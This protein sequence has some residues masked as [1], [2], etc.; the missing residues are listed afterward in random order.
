[1]L[2]GNPLRAA[3]ISRKRQAVLKAGF[4]M[5]VPRA[6]VFFVPG[7]DA[8]TG[9][10][11][12]ILSIADESRRLQSI[13]GASV[14]V[15]TLPGHPPL[16][17]YTRFDNSET[18]LGIE[19]VWGVLGASPA[20][21]IHVPEVHV[22]EALRWLERNRARIP[23]DTAINVLLQNVDL[24]PS[25]ADM[26]RLASFGSLSCTTAHKAYSTPEFEARLGCP[27]HHLSAWVSPEGYKRLDV[28]QKD[29]LVI[30][31]RDVTP[32]KSDVLA[33]LQ[34]AM[35]L[36]AF[37]EIAGLTYQ[38]YKELITRARF[39]VTFGEGLD[40]YLVEPV[41]SGGVGSAVYNDRFFTPDFKALDFI[42]SSWDDLVGRFPEDAA[43]CE[44][45]A[46]YRAVNARQ[47]EHL[48]G[49]YSKD[50]YVGNIRRFYEA[51]FP[52]GG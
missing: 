30:Y 41:F 42:Y 27:L 4:P 15:C 51:V 37:R 40:G 49:I 26:K 38:Q 8:V 1:M 29:R 5:P 3:S 34:R 33:R 36:F 2:L 31:S 20:L 17:R 28:S 14:F 48:A 22:P 47:F 12:S 9:G 52:N 10:V 44:D 45:E 21:M 35:P 7:I 43:R 6:I 25:Q 46:T 19:D 11:M 23:R 32:E 18:L 16:F 50:V 13:H 39:S 24:C